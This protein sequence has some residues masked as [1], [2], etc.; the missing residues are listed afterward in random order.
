MMHRPLE[1]V[2]HISIAI[3]YDKDNA[4]IRRIDLS[5]RFM[6]RAGLKVYFA[7]QDT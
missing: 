2:V 6:T 4:I 1:I 5:V 7:I 3:P